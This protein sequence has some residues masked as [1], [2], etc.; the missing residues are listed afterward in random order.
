MKIAD[1]KESFV[2]SGPFAGRPCNHVTFSTSA[3]E[4]GVPFVLDKLQDLGAKKVLLLDDGFFDQPRN[5][6]FCLLQAVFHWIGVTV[7]QDIVVVVNAASGTF[8]SMG[9][10][11]GL[12]NIRFCML[13]DFTGMRKEHP[14]VVQNLIGLSPKDYIALLVDQEADLQEADVF[15]ATICSRKVRGMMPPVFV[16]LAKDN[17]VC[18][19]VPDWLSGWMLHNELRSVSIHLCCPVGGISRANG[20]G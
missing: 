1:I 2:P 14:P 11:P 5:E 10:L 18:L 3:N 13:L 12:V 8:N 6:I 17:Q 7:L 15:L 9:K 4:V 16:M 20:R 19:Q